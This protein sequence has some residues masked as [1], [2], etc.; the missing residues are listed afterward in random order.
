M[1]NEYKPETVPSAFRDRK[2]R[3]DAAV[4]G[5]DMPAPKPKTAL[6]DPKKQEP[7]V[8][9]PKPGVLDRIKSLVTGK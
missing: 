9:L 6:P 4:D 3:I 5:D 1:G 8:G 2:S 7:A